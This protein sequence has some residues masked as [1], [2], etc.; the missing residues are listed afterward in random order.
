MIKLLK[1]NQ[2]K[3][4]NKNNLLIKYNKILVNKMKILIIYQ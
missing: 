1:L 3:I 2:K 4:N